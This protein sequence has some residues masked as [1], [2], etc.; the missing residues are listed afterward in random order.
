MTSLYLLFW[1]LASMDCDLNASSLRAYRWSP[2]LRS[3]RKLLAKSSTDVRARNSLA[4]INTMGREHRL[5]VRWVPGMHSDLC[6][7]YTSL[8]MGPSGFSVAIQKI[9]VRSIPILL[10]CFHR[11]ALFGLSRFSLDSRT[12]VCQRLD[13]DFRPRRR[14]SCIRHQGK[15]AHAFPRTKQT[16]AKRRQIGRYT[17]ASSSVRIWPAISEWRGMTR[18]FY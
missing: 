7:R 2:C 3:L 14:S 6:Y 17:S 15:E 4:N 9:W 18:L 5:L 13:L 8:R 1:K 11:W 16:Q 12:L 10:R